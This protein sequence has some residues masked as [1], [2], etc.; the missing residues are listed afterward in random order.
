MNENSVNTIKSYSNND[1]VSLGS[2]FSPNPRLLKRNAELKIDTK[3]RSIKKAIN[4]IWKGNPPFAFE[5]VYE[6][7]DIMNY[8]DEIYLTVYGKNFEEMYDGITANDTMEYAKSKGAREWTKERIIALN[9]K[10]FVLSLYAFYLSDNSFQFDE[11]WK[12]LSIIITMLN[13]LT[14]TELQSIIND[15]EIHN[16]RS[17]IQNGIEIV[18]SKK[19]ALVMRFYGYCRYQINLIKG[20]LS[21]ERYLKTI[22]E[23][24]IEYQ[25]YIIEELNKWDYMECSLRNKSISNV[26]Y[27]FEIN[28]HKLEMDS[29]VLIQIGDYLFSNGM[30]EYAYKTYINAFVRMTDKSEIKKLKPRIKETW[31]KTS[32]KGLLSLRKFEKQYNSSEIS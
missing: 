21:K 28:S 32:K 12:N 4:E 19:M 5:I 14:D 29:N 17:I 26:V 30:Y 13:Q 23:I 18:L 1:R 27:S 10:T 15:E 2:P 6:N 22:D 7:D 16:N 31:K 3:N 11:F 9:W 8:L 25:N 20:N 24:T